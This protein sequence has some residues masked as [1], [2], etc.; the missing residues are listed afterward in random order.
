VPTARLNQCAP[1]PPPRWI[2]AAPLAGIPPPPP[3]QA[4]GPHS[5][6][7]CGHPPPP[8]SHIKAYPTNNN[9]RLNEVRRNIVAGAQHCSDC[10]MSSMFF[11]DHRTACS[12]LES[13]LTQLLQLVQA[14]ESVGSAQITAPY[15]LG[16]SSIYILNDVVSALVWHSENTPATRSSLSDQRRC[17][18]GR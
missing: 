18:Q 7:P 17:F 4:R 10:P 1:Q 12:V 13:A 3:S 11:D 9:D 8:P 15:L 14:H 2:P 5:R 6:C 16:S